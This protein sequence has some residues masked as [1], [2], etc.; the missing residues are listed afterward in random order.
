MNKSI[1]NKLMFAGILGLL[2]VFGL[3]TVSGSA[4]DRSISQG[5]SLGD[6]PELIIRAKHVEGGAG[7]R[8]PPPENFLR[9]A[10]KSSTI[11]VTYLGVWPDGSKAA[12]QFAADIWE[13]QIT[14][15]LTIEVR[16]TMTDTLSPVV[17]GSAG[18]Y[19]LHRDFNGAPVADTFYPSALA[20][21]L[22]GTDLNDVDGYDYD[23][24]GADTDA[25]I[26]AKFNS[27]RSDW[28]YGT[29]GNVGINQFDFVSVVLHEIGHGLGFSGSMFVGAPYCGPGNGCWGLL[30][31]YPIIYDRFAVNNL[32]QSLL[33]TIL[34]PNDSTALLAELTGDNLFFNGTN[35]TAANGGVSPKLYAPSSWE[36]GSSF[37]H[38]DEV[39]YPMTNTNALMTPSI[40]NGESNHDPGPITLG[41]FEDIGWS[42]HIVPTN[43]L[44][45]PI[46]IK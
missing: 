20:N 11:H 39:T 10:P 28:Y 25:E 41:I 9:N 15:P 7:V 14:S 24:D 2:F 13:T 46:I 4:S 12:F 43:L 34:F 35:A 19:S 27:N 1:R 33:D 29:D 16:A 21:K 31:D 45:L 18:A 23:K 44:Y 36:L 22:A 30:S 5:Y 26:R 3:V 6:A 37:S 42:L 8:I 38:L 32:G 40:F 17:L